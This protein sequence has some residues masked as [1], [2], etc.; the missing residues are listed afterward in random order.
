MERKYGVAIIHRKTKEVARVV[1]A[2]SLDD[3]LR[4]ERGVQI[5]LNRR[6]Y[7]TQIRFPEEQ[8]EVNHAQA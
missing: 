7:R 6:N 8:K 3:A 2:Y 1:P 4:I 5:N